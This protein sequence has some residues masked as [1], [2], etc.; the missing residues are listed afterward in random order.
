MAKSQHL[1]DPFLN[2][3]RKEKVEV[4][5]FLINGVKLVGYISAF[6]QFIIV[7]SS[8]NTSDQMVYKHAIS[9]IKPEKS[10][11][12]QLPSNDESQ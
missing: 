5:I 10:V 1:Q 8:K 11:K 7:L 4:S 12:Y 3:C 2:A 6:D 9:T